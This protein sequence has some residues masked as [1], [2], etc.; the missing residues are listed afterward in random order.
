VH[1]GR[2][3]TFIG[4]SNISGKHQQNVLALLA[5]S[6]SFS[7]LEVSVSNNINAILWRKLAVNCVINP[8]TV[9]HRCHNGELLKKP[10][11]LAQIRQI[12]NEILQVSAA[13]DRSH[14]IE[15]LYEYVTSV[16]STTADNRSSMLQDV[17]AGRDTEIDAIT[18]YLCRLADQHNINVPF[19]KQLLAE[20]KRVSSTNRN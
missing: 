19:N 12:I 3:H 20:I 4:E 10:E 8:L 18:G 13:L 15:D 14:W 6:L 1:A 2:G 16:A 7:P 9:R 11:S 5:T 17:D